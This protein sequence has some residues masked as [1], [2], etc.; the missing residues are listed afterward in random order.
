MPIA[1]GGDQKDRRRGHS[2]RNCL[3]IF[4]V[5]EYKKNPVDVLLLL[6]N[7]TP[8]VGVGFLA[9]ILALN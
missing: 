6:N 2:C 5:K 1:N 7:N 3:K 8:L 9:V 4:K